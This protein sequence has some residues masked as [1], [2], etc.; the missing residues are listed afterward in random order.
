MNVNDML[1]FI[2]F[3]K[4][5]DTY[6]QR[7]QALKDEND[8]LEENIRATGV[9]GNV[10]YLRDQAK[11]D[12]QAAADELEAAKEQA[13]K[14]LDEAK[15]AYDKRVQDLKDEQ[16]VAEAKWQEGYAALQQAQ[17]IRQETADTLQAQ[18]NAVQADRAQLAQSQ[19]EVDARL[20]KLQQVMR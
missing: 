7:L 17:A 14:L 8:R 11:T 13:A 18:L 9:V 1:D 2:A 12:R 19:A 4:D 5:P 3:I 20:E 6:Q 15:Y 16:A 10:N